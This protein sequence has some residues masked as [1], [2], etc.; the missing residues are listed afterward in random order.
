MAWQQEGDRCAHCNLLAL[1]V[2]AAEQTLSRINVVQIWRHSECEHVLMWR[3]VSSS[4]G[5]SQNQLRSAHAHSGGVR[6]FVAT[7]G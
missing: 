4:N 3:S 7:C 1:D 5:E 6:G 2:I